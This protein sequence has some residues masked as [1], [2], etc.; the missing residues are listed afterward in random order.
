MKSIL[1]LQK[2]AD[3]QFQR[4]QSNYKLLSYLV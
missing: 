3:D 2:M 4:L 1:V